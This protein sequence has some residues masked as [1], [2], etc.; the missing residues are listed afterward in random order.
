MFTYLLDGKKVMIK[1]KLTALGILFCL[2]SS[3]VV[4]A[5]TNRGAGVK[6][7]GEKRLALVIGNSA[8][9]N[10]SPLPN[11]QN[12]AVD[13]KAT[14]EALGFEVI[15]GVNQ[16]SKQMKALI[17]QFG[18]KLFENKG[19]GLFYYAG[20]GV[21]S[22]GENYLV[23]V[24]ADIPAEDEIQDATVSLS[25][26][27]GKMT[28]AGNSL[29]L[30][31]L[32]ACRNNPFARN[33]RTVRDASSNGGLATIT[34]APSGTLIAYATAP[35]SVASDGDGKNGLY[36]QE[37]LT[38]MKKP[39]LAIEEVFKNVRSEVRRKSK[40]LQTPW[41]SSSIEGAFYFKKGQTTQAVTPGKPDDK[42]PVITAKDNATQEREA[43]NLVKNST[44]A[45]D[46]RDFLREFPNGANA[47]NAKIKLEQAIWDSVSSSGDANKVKGYLDEFPTGANA[48]SGRI[49]YGQLTRPKVQLIPNNSTST[50][51]TNPNLTSGSIAAGTVVTN[52]LGMRF[53]YSPAGTFEMGSSDAEIDEAVFERKKYIADAKRSDFADETLKRK[54][55]IK[56]GFYM[57]KY[58]ITQGQWQAVMGDNPSKFPECG[59]NCPVENVSWDDIQVFV[60]RL[61]AKDSQFEYRLPTEAEWE[62]AARAG[63]TTAFAFGGSLNASQANFNGEYPY[64][65]TKGKNIGKT[66]PVGSYQPNAFGLYDMHGN[67][68]EWVQ[69]MYNPSYNNLPTDGS[70]NMSVGDS[71]L[72]VLRG[73]S[74]NLYGDFCRSAVRD[75]DAPAYRGNDSGFR[76]I[77]RAK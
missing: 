32:D 39:D 10:T 37:L 46:L 35:G 77:A 30:V 24:D 6:A 50:T 29:N 25:F 23:P 13:M 38:Q 65:S 60:K 33:W 26:L 73:G 42:D 51:P 4:F 53:G 59:A 18:D 20:H 62:Y 22:G 36:T 9:Q 21:A 41:E 58:E 7:T 61:N 45:Q 12:D 55:M 48:S 16:N 28:T 52:S 1:R 72:R 2:F 57:G 68:W 67:V 74:W 43:W 66:V 47:T 11:P 5:Q 27:L 14:L 64:A 15:Y 34:R 69:D 54:V 70:A 44:D 17:R 19:V 71:G 75:R 8:Y 49:L 56:E 63:T 40:N 3:S 31:I 76:L